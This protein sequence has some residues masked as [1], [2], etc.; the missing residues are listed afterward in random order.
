MNMKLERDI[1]RDLI[2]YLPRL[3]LF[4]SLKDEIESPIFQLV[5]DP[6]LPDAGAD[7]GMSGKVLISVVT[8]AAFF[9]SVMLVFI[10][11]AVKNIRKN[12]ARM[13]KLKGI[14]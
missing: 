8:M 14:K 1:R 7:S 11:N 9:L 12:P 6:G 3:I 5:E 10:L 13:K 4:V 2:D